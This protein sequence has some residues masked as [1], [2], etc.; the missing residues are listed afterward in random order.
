M[1]SIL[2]GTSMIPP[3]PHPALGIA[4]YAEW[5]GHLSPAGRTDWE[6]GS[7]S[8]APIDERIKDDQQRVDSMAEDRRWLATF[9]LLLSQTGIATSSTARA[10]PRVIRKVKRVLPGLSHDV[11]VIDVHKPV[12]PVESSGEGRQ[13]EWSHRWTVG[14]ETG[15]FWRQ[16]AYGPNHS[17]RRPQ[18]IAPFIKG[19]AD[20]P[21][22]IKDTVHVL[23]DGQ[24]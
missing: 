7:D 11:R 9:F 15:G 13:V 3:G 12:V 19:P 18:F 4:M 17:L 22:K 8:D 5:N 24:L 20:K 2:W 1:R 6:W 16:Q 14:L 21:L 23:K 10:Q